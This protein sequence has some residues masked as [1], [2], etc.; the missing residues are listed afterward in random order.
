MFTRLKR[1]SQ[2]RDGK[3]FSLIELIFAMVLLSVGLLGIAA[4]FPL[5]TRFVSAGKVT[6]TA[7]ALAGEKME[8]LESLPLDSPSLQAGSYSDQI[9]PYTRS[10][11]IADDTPMLGVKHLQV[12]TSWQSPRGTRQVTLETYVFRSSC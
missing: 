1:L 12:T 6:S 2:R 8:E 5:G 10:W 7:V 4:V 11:T 3:G 9:D